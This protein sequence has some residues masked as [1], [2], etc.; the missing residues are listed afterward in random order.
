LERGETIKK[1]W[2]KIPNDTD[3]LITHG[4]P[5]GIL[6]LNS[7]REKCGCE[8]LLLAVNRVRPKI[9][10]FG[11]IHEAYGE[12]KLNGTHFINPCSCDLSYVPR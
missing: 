1:V 3:V 11:H 4:P 12:V 2:D 10:I 6:D 9:H 7:E 5:H 8:E